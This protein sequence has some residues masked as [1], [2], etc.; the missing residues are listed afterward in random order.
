MHPQKVIKHSACNETAEN[1]NISSTGQGYSQ[2]KTESADS[3][4]KSKVSF[5][6]EDESRKRSSEEIYDAEIVHPQKVIKHSACNEI[7]E[8]KNIFSSSNQELAI[9]LEPT[10]V[11][12][13][14]TKE[15]IWWP[16]LATT[17]I[18]KIITATKIDSKLK[19]K[20][21]KMSRDAPK[22][23]SLQGRELIHVSRFLYQHHPDDQ[24]PMHI[25]SKDQQHD[26]ICDFFDQSFVCEKEEGPRGRAVNLAILWGCKSED[27]TVELVENKNGVGNKALQKRVDAAE[28]QICNH[29]ERLKKLE[30][31][32][33]EHW[34]KAEDMRMHLSRLE[35][36]RN[37]HQRKTDEM[38]KDLMKLK[39]EKNENWNKTQDMRMDLMRLE[40]ENNEYLKKTQDMRMDLMKLEKENSDCKMKAKQQSESIK[41]LE[42]DKTLFKQKIEKLTELQDLSEGLKAEL[43]C[44]ICLDPFDNPYMNPDCGHRFC[45]R[46]IQQAISKSGK[47][48]PLCRVKITSK[49][50][51]RKDE[52]IGSITN[53]VFRDDEC[54]E[55][56]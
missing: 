25:I 8:N 54:I 17:S 47:E 31:E 24:Q 44:P 1:K 23:N 33:N 46:C 41:Q 36:E 30:E 35:E 2:L 5:S 10:P 28:V 16:A 39:E 50:G 15:S 26:L 22:S 21:L 55:I 13:R 27:D 32:K 34:R 53:V 20:M 56:N 42:E 9:S 12:F 19:F 6:I 51:L 11:L 18:Q 43:E 3:K 40:K 45:Y 37:E 4:N 38:R 14:C 49:R 7:A 29:N 48:C 52:L